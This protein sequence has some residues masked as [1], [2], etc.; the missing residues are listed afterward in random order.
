MKAYEEV[1]VTAPSFLTS[2]IDKGELPD[3]RPGGFILGIEPPIF[4]R[5]RAGWAPESFW[6]L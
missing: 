2:A 5:I 6:T 3:S 4:I 1:E